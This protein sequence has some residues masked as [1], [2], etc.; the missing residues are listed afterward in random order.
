MRLLKMILAIVFLMTVPLLAFDFDIDDAGDLVE[1][2]SKLKVEG[3]GYFYYKYD[4]SD[5]NSQSN[6]FDFGRMYFGANYRLSNQFSIRYLTD[7]SQQ[8][9]TSKFKVFP[10]YAYVDWKIKD[11]LSLIMGLQG[12]NNWKEPENAWGYRSIYYAPLEAF[13]KF[14]EVTAMT[15]ASHL[16][17]L[18]QGNQS[19][20]YER[21]KNRYRNFNE[22][23]KSGMGS[24]ADMGVTAKYNFCDDY[25]A[26]LSVINGSG[27]KERENDI[28]KNVQLRVG[29]HQINKRLHL[30]GYVELEP[31]SGSSLTGDRQQYMNVQWDMMASFKRN[32]IFS[33][34]VDLN[35]KK[36][37][38]IETINAFCYSIFGNFHIFQ[39]QLLFLARY[40]NYSTGI[41]H[42]EFFDYDQVWWTN[43]G[44]LILGLDYKPHKNI[45]IIP[46]LQ[47]KS[48]DNQEYRN[49]IIYI[50]LSFGFQR[51]KRIQSI[52]MNEQVAECKLSSYRVV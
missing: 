52:T 50:H 11:G 30:S 48:Y 49:K 22:A 14:W 43:G 25:Y 1:A 44:L 37:D 28:Y 10:K 6:S 35:G 33:V 15:Y 12:T 29:S 51:E 16:S 24:S 32:G 47:M 41:D 17:Y 21:Q 9:N 38:G 23:S 18:Y 36:F 42:A 2:L 5:N 34:G 3:K 8:G 45:S 39:E 27:Y 31:W 26:N 40:D 13:G 19:E 7:F 4:V 20:D 46:N